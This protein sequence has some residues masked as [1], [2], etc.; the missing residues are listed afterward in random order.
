MPFSGVRER[1]VEYI[2]ERLGFVMS[3]RMFRLTYCGPL[4]ALKVIIWF[5]LIVQIKASRRVDRQD[6]LKIV[7]NLL[8]KVFIYFLFTGFR[9]KLIFVEKLWILSLSLIRLKY[10]TFNNVW[11]FVVA[12]VHEGWLTILGHIIR[13]TDPRNFVLLCFLTTK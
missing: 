11:L 7:W 2:V 6:G 3:V 10:F 1:A 5:F 8:I 12:R 4:K 9:L 13:P